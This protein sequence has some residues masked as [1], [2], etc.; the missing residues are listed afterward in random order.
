MHSRIIA[1]N[2]AELYHLA[3]ERYGEL[4]AFAT[5]K[6]AVEWDPISFREL[7]ERGI[8]LATGL[9]EMGVDA[10]DHVG[11]FGDNRL[12][13]ILADYGVQLCGAADVPRGR[14]ITD[15]ELSYIINHS[16]IRI[17]FVETRELR[18][19]LTRL[20]DELPELQH[21]ITFERESAEDARVRLL[22][23]VIDL[24]RE[25]RESGDRRVEERMKRIRP[26][27]L[28]TLI[29]TSGTT[30]KPKGVMLSHASMMSQ[31]ENIPLEVGP[32]DRVISVLPVWHIFERVFEV[33]TI[34]SG[35]CTYYSSIRTLG[36][37]LKNVEPT[38]MGSAPRLWESLHQRILKNVRSAHPV[39]RALFHIAYFLSRHYRSSV[40]YLTDRRL[41]LRP[42]NPWVQAALMCVHA[43][44]WAVLLPWYGFFNAAVLER[45]RLAA[46][47][48]LKATISGGGALPAE[49][50]HFFNSI[51][52]P[53]LEGYG[54]TETA[55]VLSVRT[56]RRLVIGTVGPMIP[57]TELQI[58]NLE[59]G[60]VLYPDAEHEHG[61]RGL[62]GEICVRGPQIM[63]GYYWEDDLTAEVL[64]NGWFRT[65]DLGMVTFNDCLKILGRCKE[66]VV[67]SSGENVEPGPIEMTLRQS[68]LIEQCM[69][70][71]QDRKFLGVLVVPDPKGFA[72]NGR[73]PLTRD[74]LTKSEEAREMI[75]K[76]IRKRVNTDSRFKAFEHIHGV[77]L[78]GES[79]EVGEELTNLHKLKRHVIEEKFAEQIAGIFEEQSAKSRKRRRHGN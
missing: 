13:W 50:D 60:T 26:T 78:L 9:I 28:F 45:I 39:R 79:F 67:L 69:V 32:T 19:R 33:L 22:G 37:D 58:R 68:T 34:S 76:E 15:A 65:G 38:F 53:V 61:G 23:E 63:R 3:A 11:L 10:R 30:G 41:A 24:G 27:D 7:Y 57:N 46:G 74:E 66:T 1:P 44:R 56:H 47:G 29:Y 55:P 18:E 6:A 16:G 71:G 70:V 72:E 51:G 75:R 12:E 52:I 20:W 59:D 4:P 73:K 40:F 77:A 35:V 2:L 43:L 54:L 42:P 14:D 49:I 48:G 31:M 64:E 62:R 8:S 21:L 25:L 36:D 5:R 17:A